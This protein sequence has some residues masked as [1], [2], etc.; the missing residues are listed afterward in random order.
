MEFQLERPCSLPRKIVHSRLR[1]QNFAELSRQCE[2]SETCIHLYTGGLVCP[3]FLRLHIGSTPSQIRNYAS[4]IPEQI[5]VTTG[6]YT[7]SAMPRY[8]YV[9]KP[10]IHR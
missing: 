5:L 10:K 4:F 6:Q 1:A 2:N 3:G 8:T 9:E 7:F